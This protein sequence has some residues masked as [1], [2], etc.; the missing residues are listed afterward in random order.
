MFSKAFVYFALALSI[1]IIFIS[2]QTLIRI[3]DVEEAKVES[4]A[5]VLREEERN[6]QLK[7]TL[8]VQNTDEYLESLA[9]KRLGL[10]KPGEVVYKIVIKE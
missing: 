2:S 1:Y 6:K 4:L 3:R 8:S 7:N 10:V 5:A 9:R